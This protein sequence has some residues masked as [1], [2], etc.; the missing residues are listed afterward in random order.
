MKIQGLALL[1]PLS[2]CATHNVIDIRGGLVPQADSEG[3]DYY[4]KFELDYGSEDKSRIAGSLRGFIASGKIAGLTENDPFFKWWNQ[5]LETGPEPI[6]G[7]LKPF[8]VR[9]LVTAKKVSLFKIASF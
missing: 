4:E 9:F 3:G 2:C 7:R 5:Y 6:K 8:Y 1:L